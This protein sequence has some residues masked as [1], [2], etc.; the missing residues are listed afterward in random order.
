MVEHR[1]PFDRRTPHERPQTCEELVER[2]G[3]RKVVVG[4][5]VEPCNAVL[6]GIPRREHQD[7]RPDAS[8]AQATAD[9]ESVETREHHIEDDRVEAGEP[10]ETRGFLAVSDYVDRV[11][12]LTQTARD[13]LGKLP[14]V[15]HDQDM[16]W[17]I[18]ALRR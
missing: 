9:G 13:Q 11:T 6:D 7:R 4:A 16:H 12:F 2:E 14:L 8:C 17:P 10:R 18:L 5:G 15:L 3:L 1:R